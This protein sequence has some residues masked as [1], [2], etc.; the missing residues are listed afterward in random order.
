[1]GLS[2][3]IVLSSIGFVYLHEAT[4]RKDGG[5]TSALSPPPSRA[6]AAA[7]PDAKSS[8][9]MSRQEVGTDDSI[10]TPSIAFADVHTTMKKVPSSA[11]GQ[12]S[13]IEKEK[14]QR[15]TE[16]ESVLGLVKTR[17]ENLVDK[18]MKKVGQMSNV[19][20]QSSANLH[21]IESRIATADDLLGPNG[22]IAKERIYVFS[23]FYFGSRY[24]TVGGRRPL[25]PSAQQEADLRTSTDGLPRE[26]S[27]VVVHRV[28]GEL[29]PGLRHSGVLW[30]Y[31]AQ[32]PVAQRQF[33]R[34]V[35]LEML[36]VLPDEVMV[37]SG[38]VPSNLVT[39]MVAMR[40]ISANTGANMPFLAAWSQSPANREHVVSKLPY[41]ILRTIRGMHAVNSMLGEIM[42][43]K[44][45]RVV[46]S[47]I[48]LRQ[49]RPPSAAR[50]MRRSTGVVQM[51]AGGPS[52]PQV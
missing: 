27:L 24:R 28:E 39:S 33:F 26:G 47:A 3:V 41:D 25:E 10:G 6:V 38:V 5:G 36:L 4:A 15:S 34:V 21:A 12:E 22:G 17:A 35:S 2:C 23:P 8:K 16:A 42:V 30:C 13:L 1:M 20:Q 40:D 49:S 44:E 48:E 19:N 18:K 46:L 7:R 31:D 9:Y 45:Y 37:G 52:Q 43:S 50:R 11:S 32:V 14:A 51:Y 29:I